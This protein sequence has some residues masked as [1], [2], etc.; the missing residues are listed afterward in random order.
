MGNKSMPRKKKKKNGASHL[1]CRKRGCHRVPSETDRRGERSFQSI[2]SYTI[3][4][5]CRAPP[6]GYSTKEVT[7]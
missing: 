5:A 3:N 1:R 2:H 4:V 7:I 6:H